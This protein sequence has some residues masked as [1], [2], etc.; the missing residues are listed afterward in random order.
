MENERANRSGSFLVWHTEMRNNSRLN[1]DG[2]APIAITAG[3]SVLALLIVLI[4]QIT[5]SFNAKNETMHFV[6]ERSP[7]ANISRTGSTEGVGTVDAPYGNIASAA[8]AASSDLPP[9]SAAQADPNDF[10]QTGNKVAAQL[11]ATYSQMQQSGSYT[12]AQ[13]ERVADSIASSLYANV[14]YT[15]YTENDLKTDS[16]TSYKRM[17]AYRSDMR[18]ALQPLMVNT[19]MELEIFGRYIESHDKKNL[20]RLG[21]IAERYEKSAANMASVTIPAD[22]ISY[23][24]SVA[25]SLLQFAATLDAMVK[26]ANDPMATL[27]LLRTYNGA[28]QNV[29]TSFNSLAMYQKQKM[30]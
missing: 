18:T 14:S 7:N 4:W 15:P 26:N 9:A 13:G 22:A 19:E 17:L 5:Q 20:A 28:E 8:A 29:L 27:A 30:P 3:I 21:E 10:S 12:P 16:D 6:A 11:A 24:L 2:F 25:N 1:Q 23:H